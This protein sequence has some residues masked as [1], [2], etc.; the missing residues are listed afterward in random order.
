MSD[1]LLRLFCPSMERGA[2][3]AFAGVFGIVCNLLL[4]A[5][6]LAVGIL[7]GSIA[8]TADALNNFSDAA[9][10]A[11][12]LL[13]FRLAEKPADQDHPYGHARYEYLAGLAVAAMMV[14]IGFELART[15]LEKLLRPQEVAFDLTAGAVLAGAVL[16]KLYMARC[17]RR[18]GGRISS[19]TLETAAA[20]SRSDAVATAAVLLAGLVERFTGWKIDGAAGL[21]AAGYVLWNGV[22]MARTT[23]NPLLGE[24]ASPA[25]RRQIMD[26][27]GAEPLVLGC[28]DLLVH[29]YGP[30]RRFASLHVEMDRREDPLACHEIIDGLE[31]RCFEELGVH[32]VIHYDP[33]IRD[34]PALEALKV[35]VREALEREDPRLTLHD[36]RLHGETLRF[37]VSVPDGLAKLEGDIQRRLAAALPEYRVE[38]TF[39]PAAGEGNG[40][41][42][43]D[44]PS[45]TD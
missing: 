35:R 4:T 28:H 33:V 9:S 45:R 42:A 10:G 5:A 22:A 13:G 1:I 16:V 19:P 12:T 6:K 14:V 3:G 21:A 37:D 40:S 34:D 27:M 18:W 7:S 44:T 39:D 23:I 29:D 20:D 2:V 26:L 8:V 25:L 36:L 24:G 32:L 41:P 11:V 38:V 15:S 30:G 31:H 17:Y 43:A